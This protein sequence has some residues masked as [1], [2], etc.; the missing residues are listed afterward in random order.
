[1]FVGSCCHAVADEAAHVPNA[2]R[3]VAKI[4][5]IEVRQKQT[6]TVETEV[7]G[8]KGKPLKMDLGGQRMGRQLRLEMHDV[9]DT[10]PP[11]YF[12]QFRLVA[13]TKERVQKVLAEPALVT[14][15]GRPAKFVS[16]AEKGDRIEIE[17]TV[18]EMG[19]AGP[20][21]PGE[22]IATRCGL[23]LG[24]VTPRII[25]QEEEEFLETLAP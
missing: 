23:I 17:L 16:G 22:G 6:M 4:K 3:F 12:A 20:A 18:K 13:V 1:M 14:V 15:V 21:A 11:Q 8:T 9:P 10:Q 7:T 24:G 19:T 5:F 25:I 2:T